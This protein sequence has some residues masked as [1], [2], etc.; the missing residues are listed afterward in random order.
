MVASAV[1]AGIVGWLIYLCLENP[2]GLLKEFGKEWSRTT[3]ISTAT[4]IVL[5]EI[6]SV[7]APIYIL[8]F[9]PALRFGITAFFGGGLSILLVGLL[10]YGIWPWLLSQPWRRASR[11]TTIFCVALA[12]FVLWGFGGMAYEAAHRDLVCDHPWQLPHWITVIGWD[13][14]PP[15]DDDEDNPLQ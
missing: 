3:E 7:A 15:D 13:H 4:I 12:V 14:C 10:C 2:P 6:I 11:R 5:A 8:G 9:W 1:A